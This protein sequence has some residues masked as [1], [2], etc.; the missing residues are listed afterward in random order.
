[1]NSIEADV[2]SRKHGS[3]RS[4]QTWI[5]GH[6]G[7]SGALAGWYQQGCGALGQLISFPL[8]VHRLSAVDAGIWF[9]FQGLLGAINL[10]DFGLTFVLTRQVAYSLRLRE[11]T[12]MANSDFIVTQ[13][14]WNGVA[15]VFSLSKK[16]FHA[17]GVVA[18]LAL[19]VIY[20]VVSNFGKLA[21]DSSSRTL[22]AWCLLGC[23]TILSLQAKPGQAVIEG[24]AKVYLTRFLIGTCQLLAAAGVIACLL[25]GGGMVA[26]AASVAAV[27]VIQWL[28]MGAIATRQGSLSQLKD[29]RPSPGLLRKLVRVAVPM[30]VL[31]LSAFLTSSVQVP[32]LGSILGPVIV[33]PFYLAQKIG[34]ALNIA[35]TQLIGPQTPL[36]THEL[37]DGNQTAAVRRMKRT[38]LWAT[39][40]VVAA[41]LFFLF[42]SPPLVNL[43]VGPGRYIDKRTL[44]LM[45]FDYS[46]LGATVAWA[47]FVFA[48]GRNPF[49]YSTAISA[50]LNVMLIFLLCPHLGLTG[51]PLATLGS[52]LLTNYW[53][54]LFTGVRL[55]KELRRNYRSNNPPNPD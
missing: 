18:A 31:N 29:V 26:M 7:K 19:A 1:M 34:Q 6:P 45:S 41:N 2:C 11:N 9:S 33:P 4:A 55:M 13:P 17:L 38:L 53:Y 20:L 27:S 49:V 43:W 39:I 36:F 12:A 28:A 22:A 14:G 54:T 10:A 35:V 5:A 51:I 50:V 44:I 48:A 3:F 47:Q 42:A 32:L 46:L 8:V 30:G 24:V 15:E 52:G 25:A 21:R 16:L 40:S 23:G 37:A